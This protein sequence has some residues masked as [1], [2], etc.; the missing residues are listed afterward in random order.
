MSFPLSDAPCAICCLPTVTRVPVLRTDG[1]VRVPCCDTC[2]AELDEDHRM[3]LL[4][5]AN[6]QADREA[7]GRAASWRARRGPVD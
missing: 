1:I 6:E 5:A 4:L 3:A 7:L 2:T